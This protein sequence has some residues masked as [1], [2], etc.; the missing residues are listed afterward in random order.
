MK[1]LKIAAPFSLGVL[2]LG[3]TVPPAAAGDTQA[4]VQQLL[5]RVQQQAEF[6]RKANYKGWL[7][8]VAEQALTRGEAELSAG[9][10]SQAFEDLRLASDDFARV[11]EQGNGYVP[12]GVGG[13]W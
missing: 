7:E 2:L 1:A 13:G 4:D 8:V 11:R 12:L 6:N 5:E 9:K 3:A 10:Y